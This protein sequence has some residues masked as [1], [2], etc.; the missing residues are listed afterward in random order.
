HDVVAVPEEV[1]VALEAEVFERLDRHDPVDRVVELLPT[2]QPDVEAA[3][4]VELLQQLRTVRLLIP[5]QRQADDVDVVLLDRPPQGQTPTAPD[6]EQGH[7]RLE[8]ELVEVEVDIG[9]LR[10][11]QRGVRSGEVSAAVFPGRILEQ[12]EEV[13]RQ[14]VVRLNVFEVRSHF[15]SAD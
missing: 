3:I 12:A 9:D 15:G 6:V 8:V 11:G 4:R 14:I 1:V 10:V 2:H 5:R 13:V 7:P